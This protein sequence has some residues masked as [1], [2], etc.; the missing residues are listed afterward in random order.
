MQ[1]YRWYIRESPTDEFGWYVEREDGRLD[2]HISSAHCKACAMSEI[3]QRYPTADAD[4]RQ[5]RDSMCYQFLA[6]LVRQQRER[7]QAQ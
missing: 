6:V 1:L 2:E 7:A 5:F 4:L 3:V